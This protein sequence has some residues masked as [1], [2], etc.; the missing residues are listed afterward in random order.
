MDILKKALTS[1]K[2]SVNNTL[3]KGKAATTGAETI[4]STNYFHKKRTI[5]NSE[6]SENE[7]DSNEVELHIE[8]DRVVESQYDS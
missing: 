4:I 3:F 7:D 2:N 5:S 8:S 1:T 6:V